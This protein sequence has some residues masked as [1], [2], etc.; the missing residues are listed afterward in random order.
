[1]QPGETVELEVKAEK[2]EEILGYQMTLQ[3][4]GLRLIEVNSGALELYESNVGRHAGLIGLSWS[5]AEPITVKDGEPL[6]TLVFKA[7]SAGTLSG[8]L[9]V[10]SDIVKAEAYR[11]SEVSE[12]EMLD[13]SLVPSEEVYSGNKPN[14]ELESANKPEPADAGK[15]YALYQNMPNPFANETTISFDVP[16]ATGAT[17]SIYNASGQL[18]WQRGIDAHKGLN[19]VVVKAAEIE[20]KGVLLYHL[21][22]EDFSATKKMVVFE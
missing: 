3:T 14:S 4:Q 9:D 6:F 21:K 10:G 2:F 5:V 11:V 13:I 17:L 8:M 16:K 22:T 1:V 12:Y 18:V 19:K 15:D 20:S 7:N